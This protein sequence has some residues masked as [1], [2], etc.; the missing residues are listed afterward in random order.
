MALQPD[1]YANYVQTINMINTIDQTQEL[2]AVALDVFRPIHYGRI[3]R[4]L[5]RLEEQYG[6]QS[7][8]MD[9]TRFRSK[10]YWGW[11]RARRLLLKRNKQM[12]SPF[13][14]RDET[15]KAQTVEI[16]QMKA[17][18][19]GLETTIALLRDELERVRGGAV[20]PNV[21]TPSVIAIQPKGSPPNRRD[22]FFLSKTNTPPKLFDNVKGILEKGGMHIVM[23]QS[24]AKA[25]IYLLYTPGGR[26]DATGLPHPLSKMNSF[27]ITLTPGSV[28]VLANE[29]VLEADAQA[30]FLIDDSFE[31]ISTTKPWKDFGKLEA[32]AKSF[33]VTLNENTMKGLMVQCQLGGCVSQAQ[34]KCGQCEAIGYCSDAHASRHWTAGHW[35]DCIAAASVKAAQFIRYRDTGYITG[36]RL[37]FKLWRESQRITDANGA[38]LFTLGDLKVMEIYN[39]LDLN[40]FHRQ[41]EADHPQCCDQPYRVIEYGGRGDWVADMDSVPQ[42]S[43]A[44]LAAYEEAM[45]AQHASIPL[46]RMRVQSSMK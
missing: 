18:I 1:D 39:L 42:L 32:W 33:D 20:T 17:K 27:I 14:V 5:S 9:T 7:E 29:K 40:K 24:E 11:E 43:A 37:D 30:C 6:I 45:E 44:L 38:V 22:G 13:D 4:T 19:Q 15:I 35:S 2:K 28:P 25:T 31:A 10:F 21:I 34:L 46:T 8:E 23:N 41:T 16:E 26:A 12:I 3:D 36:T